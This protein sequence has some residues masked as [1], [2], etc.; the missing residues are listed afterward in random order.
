[1]LRLAKQPAIGNRLV[2]RW[3]TFLAELKLV[4]LAILTQAPRESL[5]Y[6]NRFG[7]TSTMTLG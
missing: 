6:A 5:P 3:P 4:Y 2:E 1:M 7:R